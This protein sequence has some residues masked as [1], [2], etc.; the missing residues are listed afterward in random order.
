MSDD[1]QRPEEEKYGGSYYSF[2]RA[3]KVEAE[4]RPRRKAS[5]KIRGGW[6][7]ILIVLGIALYSYLRPKDVE[8]ARIALEEWVHSLQDSAFKSG[9]GYGEKLDVE[10]R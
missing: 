3:Q 10:E 7:A 5:R 4:L 8:R 2:N 6:L 1:S 9:V